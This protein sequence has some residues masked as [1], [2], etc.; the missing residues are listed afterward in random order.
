MQIIITLKTVPFKLYFTY[1][2]QLFLFITNKNYVD[3]FNKQKHN[4]AIII[5]STLN[6][7]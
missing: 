3:S 7:K 2:L 1:T 4:P 5:H 6:A